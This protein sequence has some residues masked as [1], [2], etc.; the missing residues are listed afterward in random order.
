MWYDVV[1]FKVPL[2][3]VALTF[4]WP[5]SEPHSLFYYTA[6]PKWYWNCVSLFCIFFL[7]ICW[8]VYLWLTVSF[9]VLCTKIHY[10]LATWNLWHIADIYS[11]SWYI[12]CWDKIFVISHDIVKR[13]VCHC[14]LSRSS[15]QT[16]TLPNCNMQH[17]VE[18]KEQIPFLMAPKTLAESYSRWFGENPSTAIALT[19]SNCYEIT[20]NQLSL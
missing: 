20:E 18:H 5:M 6:R 12:S 14:V 16:Y 17:F 1:E 7:Q 3:G 4:I 19:H 2:D 10:N 11:S 13:H 9:I 15:A 8:P